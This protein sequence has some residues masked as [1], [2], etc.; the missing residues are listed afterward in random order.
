M[1]DDAHQ[2]MRD[3]QPMVDHDLTDAFMIVQSR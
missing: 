1:L 3:H 2:R